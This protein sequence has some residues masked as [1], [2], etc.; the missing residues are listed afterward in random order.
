MLV[1]NMPLLWGGR[2]ISKLVICLSLTNLELADPLFTDGAAT[3]KKVEDFILQDRWVTIQMI[4]YETDLSY[5]S[6]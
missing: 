4:M 1:H 5:G 6:E 3:V 2:E